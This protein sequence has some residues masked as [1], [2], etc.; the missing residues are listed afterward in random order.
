MYV[1]RKLYITGITLIQGILFALY[2]QTDQGSPSVSEFK[3]ELDDEVLLKLSNDS[4][5]VYDIRQLFHIPGDP[6]NLNSDYMYYPANLDQQYIDELNNKNDSILQ[7]DLEYKTLWGALHASLGGGWVH[8]TNCI[9]YALETGQLSMTA[10]LM[11]RPETAWKPRPLTD[12][13]LRTRKWRYYVPVNHRRAMKEY[14]IRK[15]IN[16]LGDLKS[17][18]AEYID[19]FLKTTDRKYRKIKNSGD[20]KSLAKI[21]LVKL[22][23]GI[24]YIGQAQIIY[25][26]SAVL[27]SVR[28]YSVG[29]LP[30]VVIFDK[31]GAA[32]VLTLDKEGYKVKAVA[33]K[34]TN[35][36]TLEG[37]NEKRAEINSIITTINDYNNRLF[38]KQL[39]NYYSK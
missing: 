6:V 9:Q 35:E 1:T 11:K 3:W 21:D 22:M 24:N 19:L 14:V 20:M 30:T 39:E 12:S 23:L 34:K 37:M 2:G 27:S 17:V 16:E 15:D 33:F 26:R 4:D 7:A 32:A 13:Y 10:P 29:K 28:S 5:Y 31:I 38:M 36:L 8:F 25:I 18:P